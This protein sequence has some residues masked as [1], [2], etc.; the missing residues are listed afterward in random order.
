ME[1]RGNSWKALEVRQNADVAGLI[2]RVRAAL[3]FDEAR[4]A[5]AELRAWGSDTVGGLPAILTWQGHVDGRVRLAS[6]RRK[7]PRGCPLAR[8]RCVWQ[9]CVLLAGLAWRSFDHLILS[10]EEPDLLSSG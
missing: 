1:T 2:A 7:P 5:H 3:R 8:Q 4:A 9:A 6:Q 10:Q